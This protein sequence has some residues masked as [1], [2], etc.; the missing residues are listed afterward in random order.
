MPTASKRAA[1]RTAPKRTA[2]PQPEHG[3]E[4]N[5]RNGAEPLNG[6]L[7]SPLIPVIR[8]AADAEIEEE[9]RA[10]LFTLDEKAY[11]IWLE[12][13]Q[14]VAARFGDIQR[15]QGSAAALSFAL[16]TMVS[17]DGYQVLLSDDRVSRDDYAQITEVVIGEI[18][19]VDRDPNNRSRRGRPAPRR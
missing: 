12:P 3:P 2:P 9:K 11:T 7:I 13:P 16:E 17:E 19:G 10:L 8:I 4:A 15:K 14:W 18:L 1:A 5:G 6:H